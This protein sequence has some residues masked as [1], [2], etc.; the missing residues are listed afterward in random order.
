MDK[1]QPSLHRLQLRCVADKPEQNVRIQFPL[2]RHC[3]QLNICFYFIFGF[4]KNPVPNLCADCARLRLSAAALE[5][6][7]LTPSQIRAARAGLDWKQ[8]DLARLARVHPR[9]IKKIERGQVRPQ[10]ETAAGIAK[11]F[12]A[13]G[14]SFAGNTGVSLPQIIAPLAPAVRVPRPAPPVIT[15]VI[16]PAPQRPAADSLFGLLAEA[17]ANRPK[18]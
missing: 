14:V 6:A 1:T 10:R 15:R 16:T 7:I 9:T 5:A 2:R 3:T 13:A 4:V 11:A 8:K 17:F 12:A 18:D